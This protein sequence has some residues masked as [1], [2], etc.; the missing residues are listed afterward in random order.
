MDLRIV[1]FNLIARDATLRT[2]LANYARRLESDGTPDERTASCFVSLRWTVDER[3]SAPAGSELLTLQVHAPRDDSCSLA[4][5]DRV[6][7]R[8]RTALTTVG[9]NPCLSARCLTTSGAV[10][11]SRFGTV[12]RTSTWRITPVS[13]EARAAAPTGLVPWSVWSGPGG[14]GLLVP[15]VGVL[16]LN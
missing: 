3:S 12:V 16:S 7:Q 13:T 4:E 1:A 8:L 10:P 2:L 15:G 5:L 9:P 6:L 11:D 14:C